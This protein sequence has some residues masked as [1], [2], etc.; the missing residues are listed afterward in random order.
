[1]ELSSISLFCRTKV[2][3][4]PRQAVDYLIKDKNRFFAV[5]QRLRIVDFIEFEKVSTIS[6]LF[7]QIENSQMKQN[8]L[9]IMSL[10]LI[11]NTILG[12]LNKE[13]ID[14]ADL[15][16]ETTNGLKAFGSQT[17]WRMPLKIITT[18]SFFISLIV[19]ICWAITIF[20]IFKKNP[21]LFI[22]TFDVFTISFLLLILLIPEM[23]LRLLFP[24]I[25]G[26]EKFLDVKNLVDLKMNIFRLNQDLFYHDNYRKI[27]D[28]ILR[29]YGPFV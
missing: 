6:D 4:E 27:K 17:G 23:I 8:I 7:V 2:R 9:K 22:V 3:V 20:I 15:T 18:R 11:E 19:F 12:F 29:L 21:S 24:N 13:S 10:N 1:M 16:Q 28:G 25:F 5:L 14:A 26:V